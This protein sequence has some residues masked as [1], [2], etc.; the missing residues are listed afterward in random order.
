MARISLT[1]ITVVVILLAVAMSLVIANLVKDDF[2]LLVTFLL[3]LG[4]YSTSVGVG[5]RFGLGSQIRRADGSYMMFWGTLVL[6][7]GVLAL[8]DHVYPG[9]M[10]WLAVGFIIWLALAI[11]LFSIRPKAR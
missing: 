2:Y 11:L 7:V 4:M 5:Q 3:I 6:V 10:F 8:I 9:N 1:S